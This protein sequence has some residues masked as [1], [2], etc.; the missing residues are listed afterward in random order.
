MSL[1]GTAVFFA[2]NA[3]AIWWLGRYFVPYS[4]G[5]SNGAAAGIAI[6]VLVVFFAAVV[7]PIAWWKRAK[8]QRKRA[9]MEERRRL[10]APEA[11][12]D[13]LERL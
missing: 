1:S 3:S 6:A 10:M 9:A 2:V 8:A 11:K 7:F 5:I 13:K 12:E 4:G